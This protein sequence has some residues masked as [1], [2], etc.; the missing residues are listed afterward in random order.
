MSFL[1]KKQSKNPADLV[2]SARDMLG[3]L[4]LA[5]DNR[6]ASSSLLSHSSRSHGYVL[7]LEL[8]NNL[9]SAY[10]SYK[11]SSQRA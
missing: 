10:F 2:R 8:D 3:K 6:K 9:Y 11:K 1:F 5:S 4:E 7:N